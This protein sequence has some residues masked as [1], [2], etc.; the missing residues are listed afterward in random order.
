[1][2]KKENSSGNINEMRNKTFGFVRN[3]FLFSSFYKKNK[4]LIVIWLSFTPLCTLS[5]PPHIPPLFVCLFLC[6]FFEY[7]S[8]KFGLF[9]FKCNQSDFKIRIKGIFLR[10]LF[11]SVCVCAVKKKDYWVFPEVSVQY[12]CER[13]F[14]SF[15]FDL[16]VLHCKRLKCC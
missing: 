6:A 16:V 8:M 15:S 5:K 12:E 11:E 7:S 2:N 10:I 1:M 13:I 4:L 9:E 14:W 3:S